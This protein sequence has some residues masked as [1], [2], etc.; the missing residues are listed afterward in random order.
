MSLSILCAF[1][2]VQNTV[3][4]VSPERKGELDYEV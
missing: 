1:K 4:I 3:N 2:K